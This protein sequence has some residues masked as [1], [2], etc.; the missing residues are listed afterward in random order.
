MSLSL[1]EQK[2][3]EMYGDEV[4]AVRAGDGHVYVVVRHVCDA[5]GLDA[6]GQTRRIQR[7]TVLGEGLTWVDILSTQGDV[8]Q[9][10]RAQVLRADLVPLWLTGIRA[11]MVKE[12]VRSKLENLQ[13]NAARLLWEAFQAGELTADADF[14]ELLEQDN[15]AVQA[16]KMLAAMMKMAR[17][18]VILESRVTSIERRLED[19]E[20]ALAPNEAVLTQNEASQIAQ[21]VKAIAMIWSKQASKNQYGAVYGRLY[22]Q[23]GIT[24]YKN[25]PRSRFKEAMDWLAEWHQSLSGDIPF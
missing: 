6:Q 14:A 8:S 5:L 15:D 11:S 13:R 25:L 9:R 24:S 23:F 3:I 17:Q 20:A 4:T 16:Y 12:D 10:R 19:V 2:E 22:E 18:Q 1:V 21:S 7:H